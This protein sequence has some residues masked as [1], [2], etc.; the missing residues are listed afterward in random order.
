[1][2]YL[3]SESW[4]AVVDVLFADA[5]LEAPR[6]NEPSDVRVA[7]KK[8]ISTHIETPRVMAAGI[9]LKNAG[10]WEKEGKG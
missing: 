9:K 7:C 10:F 4:V 3:S 8:V 2:E 6:A 1:L 5:A